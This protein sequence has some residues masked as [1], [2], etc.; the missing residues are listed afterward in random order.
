MYHVSRRLTFQRS[1][2]MSASSHTG[3]VTMGSA[4]ASSSHVRGV[5]H[6][7]AVTRKPSTS[8][9]STSRTP[10]PSWLLAVAAPSVVKAG[11]TLAFHWLTPQ[12]TNSPKHVQLSLV[13]TGASPGH[14]EASLL[15]RSSRLHAVT[16]MCRD[17]RRKNCQTRI[18]E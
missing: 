16:R 18:T 3:K 17:C 13:M 4:T 11:K 1:C 10:C 8:Q 7:T 6:D 9:P 5:L 12:H 2:A 14:R 15:S